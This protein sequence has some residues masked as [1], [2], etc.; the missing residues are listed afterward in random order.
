MAFAN[1]AFLYFLFTLI[2]P[3]LIHLFNFRQ[4]KKVWFTN[5]RFLSEIKQETKKRSQLKQLL[6][7][8]ARLLALASLILAFA[9]PYRP[10]PFQNSKQTGKQEVTVYIDN[11]FSMEALSPS[12]MLLDNAKVR[13]KEIVQS[14]K[15]TDL[16][17]LV[18]NDFEGKHQRYVSRDEFLTMA[19]EINISPVSRNL[20]D[21]ILR[22]QEQ[23]AGAARTNQQLFLISDFQKST[24]DFSNISPDTIARY[25]FIPLAA[26]KTSNIYIDSVWFES[27]V[28][29]PLQQSR[30]RVS[31][32]NSGSDPIEKIPVK[33]TLNGIQK[34][35]T[36]AAIPAQG[37]SELT[38]P[39]TNNAGGYQSG[40]IEIADYPVTFDD[41]M[42][43]AYPLVSSIPILSI[44]NEKENP[45][46]SAL[47][48][49]DTTFRYTVIN[50][51]NI[52]YSALRNYPLII[53]ND[54]EE[55]S[56]GLSQELQRYVE[57]GGN[58]V[59]FPPEVINHDQYAAFLSSLGAP[60]LEM[61]DTVTRRV[62]ILQVENPVFSDVFE[63]SPSGKVKLPENTDLPVVF[64]HYRA[65]M[66]GSN[67]LEPVMQLN[68]G[69]LFLGSVT[70]GKGKLYLFTSP[71]DEKSSNFPKHIIFVP[72]LLKIALLSGPSLGL[73]Y[74]CGTNEPVIIQNDSTNDKI[75]YKIKLDN[76][77]YE[78]I[79]EIRN[80]GFGLQL[81]PHQQIKQA[82]IYSIL[83]E[84][85]L[86]AKAAYNNDRK[87]SDLFSYNPTQID[88]SLRQTQVRFYNI[89]KDGKVPVSK[90]LSEIRQG[91]PLWRIFVI[92]TLLFIAI[93]IAIIRFVK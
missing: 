69:D 25:F 86:V 49:D 26:N 51:K 68:N 36:S 3:V 64:M 6:I 13:A 9:Q 63:R 39:F 45:Y 28:Q 34:A 30:L 54:L 91:T 67:L 8:L 53:I 29:Q 60:P 80:Q 74:I 31:L 11:S 73:Y 92:L 37:S 77:D 4:Y 10:S 83:R 44:A 57:S 90:Q 23:P 41:K 16:F 12:G 32:K 20:S 88:Q 18:T 61:K 42:Y 21:V 46:L 93:E 17:R 75:I 15:P 62:D 65:N 43:L 84:N 56:S 19:D 81:F 87:E 47:F 52:D 40:S 14:F 55:I 1:P 50:S 2:I 58:L 85:Q 82:G 22:Q 35:V 79:P 72:A 66:R 78:I 48:G 33:L 7:L 38:V 59:L 71:L 27:P 5:V 70:A 24:S 76:S 89:L